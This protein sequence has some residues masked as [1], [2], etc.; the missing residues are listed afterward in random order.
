MADENAVG[1]L[2]MSNRLLGWDE[3]VGDMLNVKMIE[4]NHYTI[5]K[6]PQ[7]RRLAEALDEI[8]KVKRRRKAANKTRG[9]LS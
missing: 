7:V 9:I 6:E 5:V 2:A 1:T 4:G 3:V 8:M